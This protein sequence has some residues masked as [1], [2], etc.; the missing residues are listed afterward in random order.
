MIKVKNN[1]VLGENFLLGSRSDAGYAVSV[2]IPTLN[3]AQNLPDVLPRLPKVVDEV[4]IV[5]GH[6]EDDTVEVATKVLPTARVILQKR[7]GK[8]DALRSAFKHA[9]GDIIVQ[10]DAD[11][12]MDP[13]EIEKFVV[14]A[15]EGYDV[16][17][18]SRYLVGGGSTDLSAKRSFGNRMFVKLVNLLF[19]TKYT[20]LCYGYMAFRKNALDRLNDALKCNGF[21]IE[22]EMCIKAKKLGLRVTEIPSFEGKRAHGSS[23]LRLIQDGFRILSMILTEFL[24]TI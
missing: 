20:D 19:S 2:V 16:V 8:G 13:L 15:S 18:G 4:I 7:N 23:R 22:T 14:L 9:N 11:G 21:Q 24:K 5:D 6:S 1:N 12:S 10:M 3:E 17:K